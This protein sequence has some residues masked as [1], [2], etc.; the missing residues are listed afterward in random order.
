MGRLYRSPA[1]L[2]ALRLI[3]FSCPRYLLLDHAGNRSL[4]FVTVFWFSILNSF[5]ELSFNIRKLSLIGYWFSFPL[6]Q[7]AAELLTKI[8]WEHF[9]F[10]KCCFILKLLYRKEHSKMPLENQKTL[11]R[12]NWRQIRSGEACKIFL[13]FL[14]QIYKNQINLPITIKI[15]IY[16]IFIYTVCNM[17]VLQTI[18]F[19][20]LYLAHTCFKDSYGAKPYNTI[21]PLYGT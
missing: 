7:A 5:F 11:V 6:F 8:L 15:D 4:P 20:Y 9:F 3:Y 21:N 16:F 17:S 18:I 10:G 2:R 14:V 1:N 13:S 19:S 12:V